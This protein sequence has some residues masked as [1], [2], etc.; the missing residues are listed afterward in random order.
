MPTELDK[1]ATTRTDESVPGRILV[2]DDESTVAHVLQLILED[3]GCEVRTAGSAEQGLELVSS[4]P[5]DVALVDIILPGMN[6]LE[7]LSRI[8]KASP[9]TEV[10]IMTSNASVE[11]A[12]QAIREGA[13]DYLQKPFDAVDDAWR[14]VQR[15]LEKRSLRLRNRSLVQEQEHRNREL[16]ATV[17]RLMSLVDAGRAM[18]EFDSLPELLDFFIGVVTRELDVERASLM[19]I[20]GDELHIAASRGIT[21]VEAETVRVPIG[22]GVAGVVAQTGEACLVTD[23]ASDPRVQNELNPSLSSSFISAPVV[24]SI[25]IKS[26]E[27]VLGVINATNRRS[28]DEFGQRDLAYLT[29]LAGQLAV[30]IERTSHFEDLQQAYESL[31]TTQQQ[32][33]RSER[34]KALG[35]M[36][37]GVAHDFNNSLAVILGRAELLLKRLRGSGPMDFAVAASNLEAIR[38]IS[39]QAAE[40]IH[41]IQGFTR[42]RKDA[43]ATAVQLNDV[44]RNVVDMTRPKWKEECGARG[45][46]VE[47]RMELQDV[48]LISGNSVE[49]NQVISNLVFNA[50][51]AMPRGGRL[52]FRSFPG[53]DH[54]V[55]EV[56]DT[57]VGMTEEVQQRIFEPFFTTKE[58]GQGLGMS[59]IYGIVTRHGG[60]I[61]VDSEVGSGSTIRVRLPQARAAAQPSASARAEA[62]TARQTGRILLVDDDPVVL[63]FLRDALGFGGH[64]VVTAGG[65]SEALSKV[66]TDSFDLVITDLSM[67]EVSGL[68][69]ARAVKHKH[70]ALPVILLSGWAVQQDSDEVRQSGVDLILSKPCAIDTLLA[71]VHKTLAGA[72]PDADDQGLQ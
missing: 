19:L 25:P 68:E 51:E 54:V 24:L 31:K 8:K 35:E 9:D 44:V 6:G 1:N 58:K 60:K 28:G 41:R 2:V 14:G 65:G 70:P 33:V 66:T 11:T 20:E 17:A 21:T 27:K 49:L 23:T 53:P 72:G 40:T 10:L 4:Y 30:A 38:N 55:L 46:E 42:I 36:A 37:A 18:G 63:D 13:Y 64:Q 34:L 67:G 29:G 39:K 62:T 59:I 47:I 69:V 16:A 57:G 43:P 5:P 52:T 45:G 56:T 26:R 12:V 50:V 7:L 22:Q 15:A 48:P 3:H 32:L 61:T 71:T